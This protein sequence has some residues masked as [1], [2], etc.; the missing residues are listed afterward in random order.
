MHGTAVKKNKMKGK[1]STY[2]FVD[3]SGFNQ[4]GVEKE[5]R[6]SAVNLFSVG[7]RS[8][9]CQFRSTREIIYGFIGSAKRIIEWY[10]DLI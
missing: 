1:K 4:W 3:I 10:I 2:I 9:L 6:S 7:P 5:Y 8:N